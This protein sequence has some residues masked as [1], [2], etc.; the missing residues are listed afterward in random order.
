MAQ[1]AFGFGDDA[2]AWTVRDDN[3]EI[4]AS[5]TCLTVK[6]TEGS[7]YSEQQ[8]TAY[9]PLEI[10]EEVLRRAKLAKGQ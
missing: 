7:G 8:T 1:W 5:A 6:A 9:I 4:S 2:D 3:V 10:L